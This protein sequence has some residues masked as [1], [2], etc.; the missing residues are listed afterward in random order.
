MRLSQLGWNVTGLGRNEAVGARL[1]AAGVRFVQADLRDAAAVARACAG[2]DAVFHCGA[3]STP[4]GDY[5]EFQAV[6]VGG[7][8]NVVDGCRKH[9]VQR[10][11]HVSTPSIYFDY[12]DRIGIR[13]SDALP[14]KPV[15][16]YA[17][18]KLQAE[19]VVQE[20]FAQGLAGL[21]LRPRAIFGP[22]DQAVFPRLMRANE[23]QGV[24]LF[25]AGNVALDLTYVDNVVD[26]MLLGWEAPQEALGLAYNISNGE[27]VML[28]DVLNELFAMMGTELRTRAIPYS[29]AYSAAALMEWSHRLLPK[30]GEPP[31]TRY[32][33]SVLAYH[34]TLDITLARELLG[35]DPRIGLSD[36][37]K[38][39]AEWWRTKGR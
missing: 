21:I 9:G 28:R 4:W 34:Q 11:I 18:T 10:L 39:F 23:S 24:P 25:R 8:R 22:L 14:A 5:R 20:A 3:L 2:Q 17:A 12:K 37:L 26:A 32:S 29:V 1:E 16:A 6:N 7:T 30:L 33:V 36:G 27:P 31:L 38:A 15:N 13:E 35:Y 19:H